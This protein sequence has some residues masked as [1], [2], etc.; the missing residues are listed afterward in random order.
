MTPS[1][2]MAR[3]TAAATPRNRRG[4]GPPAVSFVVVVT[5]RPESL[6][7]LYEDYSSALASHGYTAEFIFVA[8]GYLDELLAPLDDLAATGEP[9]RVLRSPTNIGET[10]LLRLGAAEATGR[11][12][13]TAPAYH[14]VD[15]SAFPD[16]VRKVEEGADLSIAAR[17]PRSDAAVNRIQ[18]DVMHAV[19]RRLCGEGVNDVGCGVRA[20]RRDLLQDLP[21]YG[22]FAR[23]LPFLAMN[24]GHTVVEVRAP[25]HPNDRPRR[26]YGPGVYVRRTFDVLGLAFLLRFTDKP[27]RFFGLVGSTLGVLGLV[28]LGVLLLERAAGQGIADRPMLLVGVLLVTLGVQA[29]ALGLIGEMIVHFHAAR[30]RR[31]RLRPKPLEPR[32]SQ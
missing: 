16:L 5:E 19:L 28:L 13:L 1:I 21:V 20:M 23:F 2:E 26:V 9:I 10:G 31:Y 27:L 17:W 3:P 32:D 24:Q 18:H 14:Q 4:N 30:H 8:P 29:I 7:E 12:I 11:V 25:Q 15:S 6:R 22:D